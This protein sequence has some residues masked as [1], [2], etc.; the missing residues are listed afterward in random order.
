MFEVYHFAQTSDSLFKSYIDMFL[1]IKQ[2]SSGWP[3]EC[4]TE[5]SKDRYVREYQEKEG[6]VLDPKAIQK[7][8]GKRQVAKL[9]LNSL[10]GRYILFT[11]SSTKRC[12]SEFLMVFFFFSDSG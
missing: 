1:K 4:T 3:S 2:E 6:I 9:F 5:A 12:I 11:Y 7:N 8:P 10:W